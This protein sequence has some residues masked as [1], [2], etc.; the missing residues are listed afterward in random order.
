MTGSQRTV[1]SDAELLSL[2]RDEPE[3]LAIADAVVATAPARRR[4][5]FS[6]PTIL[7]AAAAVAAA[8]AVALVAPWHRDHGTLSDLALAALGSQPVVHVVT[9]TPTGADLVDIASGAVS[10]VVQQDEIWYDGD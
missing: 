2:F 10:P 4:P 9:E 8:V 6:R 7:S 1:L 5:R 3:L